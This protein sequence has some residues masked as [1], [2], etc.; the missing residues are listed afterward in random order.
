[1]SKAIYLGVDRILPIGYTQLAY[2]QSTGTQYIDTGIIPSVGYRAEVDFQAT[3]EPTSNW[4]VLSAVVSAS[5]LWRAGINTSSFRTDGGFTYNQ[6][7]SKTSR[8]IA[9]GTCTTSLTIP[10]YLFAQNEGG[11]CEFGKYRLYKCKI[12][13]NTNKLVRYFV[14]AKNSS[15]VVGLY[16]KVNNKFY[17]AS[18]SGSFTAGTVYTLPAGG[19]ST[20]I[21]AIDIGVNNIARNVTYAYIGDSNGKAR[22][23]FPAV[24]SNSGSS[25]DSGGGSTT[26]TYTY[27][28]YTVTKWQQETYNTGNDCCTNTDISNHT[29]YSS[30]SFNTSTGK[31]TLSGSVTY[32]EVDN[33]DDEMG[34]YIEYVLSKLPCY[35]YLAGTNNRAIARIDH[36]PT[37]YWGA[38]TEPVYRAKPV[39]YGSTYTTIESATAK[40]TGYTTSSIK[41]Y[42]VNTSTGEFNSESVKYYT[43]YYLV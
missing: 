24:L 8:T 20:S 29:F 26:T 1:M 4:W 7:S 22:Q 17:T 5:K 2:I 35:I 19:V 23:V 32:S 16:D 13:D 15:G 38:W 40:T 36:N 34:D 28:Q 12:Y 25:G 21:T 11:A 6:T 30:F 27:K 39:S 10:L 43:G 33:Y 31:F 18:G 37:S 41:L 42:N 3:S 9:T 14:P